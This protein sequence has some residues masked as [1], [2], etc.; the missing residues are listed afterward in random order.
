MSEIASFEDLTVADV[1][2]ATRKVE[3]GNGKHV[4][5]RGLTRYELMLMTKGSPENDEYERRMISVC[6]VEPTL[7][8][9]QVMAWQKAAPAG[10]KTLVEVTNAIRDLSGL[11]EGADK[12]D[13]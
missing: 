12:S 4:T 8:E 2:E 10:D 6:L 7:S 3:V 1:A 9:G 5:V 11:G 13:R